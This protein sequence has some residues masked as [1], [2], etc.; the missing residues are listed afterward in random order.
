MERGLVFIGIVTLIVGL[1]CG[2][3]IY[4][5][6]Q[7]LNPA[8][9]IWMAMLAPAVFILGGM[10]MIAAGLGRPGFAHATVRAIVVC[11]L[12]IANWAAF[13]STHIQCKETVSFLGV[14]I[15]SQYPSEVECRL[16]LRVIVS[17][18]DVLILLPVLWF[19]WSR[20]QKR[21]E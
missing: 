9:P 8:W 13:F 20:W 15:L 21:K 11:L 3:L 16:G 2:Y 7:G 6:P 5:Y 4:A 10:H 17:C 14:P 18:I 19:A 12:A 1:G